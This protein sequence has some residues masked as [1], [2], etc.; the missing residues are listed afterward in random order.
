DNPTGHVHKP[1]AQ[2]EQE[3]GVVLAQ[4]GG[5]QISYPPS[6]EGYLDNPFINVMAKVGQFCRTRQPYC[7]K[8]KTV[9]QVAVLYSGHSL[10]RQA[11][12]L[13]GGWGNL[14]SA[15]EAG[16]TLFLNPTIRWIY[17]PIGSLQLMARSTR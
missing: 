11:N 5:F 2:L 9:P 4:G 15:P 10:Y 3:A 16:S 6:G 1:S 14:T 17:S 13:F 12:R 8:T 7:W